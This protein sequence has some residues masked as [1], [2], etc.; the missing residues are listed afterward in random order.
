MGSS[1]KALHRGIIIG[2]VIGAVG[3]IVKGLISGPDVRVVGVLLVCAA[4]LF[5][6][7]RR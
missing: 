3:A 2:V 6:F 1:A 4:I 7:S 5:V